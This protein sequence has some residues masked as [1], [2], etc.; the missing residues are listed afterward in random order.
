MKKEYRVSEYAFDIVETSERL[1]GFSYGMRNIKTDSAE[2]LENVDVETINE[3]LRCPDTKVKVVKIGDNYSLVAHNSV[4]KESVQVSGLGNHFVALVKIVEKANKLHEKRKEN[5]NCKSITPDFIKAINKQILLYRYGE[6]A[7]GEFRTVDFFGREIPVEF[8]IMHDGGEVSPIRCVKLERSANKNVIQKINDFC[9]WANDAFKT[10]EDI[11]VKCA[12]FHA[13]L[14]RIHP[15][16]D[17]NK[18]TCRLLVNYMLLSHNHPMVN[19]PVEAKDE[20]LRC[21]NYANAFSNEAFRNECTEYR[22]YYDKITKIYGERNEETK[23]YP[24]AKFMADYIKPRSNS[25]IK[26][27]IDYDGHDDGKNFS[28]KQVPDEEEM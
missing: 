19:I 14:V 9:E 15:F 5:P 27:M 2:L 28:A 16:R 8:D 20:Y 21:L 1:E 10:D 23:Y 4:A 3:F 11:M 13:D 26:K 22:E 17:G 24:L 12:K 18:R 7:I 25:I 6:V